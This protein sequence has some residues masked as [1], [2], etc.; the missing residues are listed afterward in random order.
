MARLPVF[1]MRTVSFLGRASALPHSN[2]HGVITKYGERKE[3]SAGTAPRTF[4]LIESLVGMR[5]VIVAR[6]ERAGVLE[7]GS[8]GE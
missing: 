8:V 2:T 4:T 6:Y 3:G 7:I 1:K 5:G